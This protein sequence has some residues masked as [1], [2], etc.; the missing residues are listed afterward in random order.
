M[1]E[2]WNLWQAA[3]T[4][5]VRLVHK[6]TAGCARM[7]L[8]RAVGPHSIVDVWSAPGVATRQVGLDDGHPAAVDS[9]DPA[10]QGG[11]LVGAVRDVLAWPR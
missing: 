7:A 3:G 9:D 1:S 11:V 6:L 4:P 5:V 2:P 8:Y 10:Q